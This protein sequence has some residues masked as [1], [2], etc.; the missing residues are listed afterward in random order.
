MASVAVEVVAVGFIAVG[1]GGSAGWEGPEVD[2]LLS[3]LLKVM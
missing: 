1:S 3:I 2:G